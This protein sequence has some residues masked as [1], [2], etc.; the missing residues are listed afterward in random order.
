MRLSL[1]HKMHILKSHAFACRGL[2][3]VY[4]PG[5]SA[6]DSQVN[7]S[8]NNISSMP[9]AGRHVLINTDNASSK[10]L[11]CESNNG[12]FPW[13]KEGSAARKTLLILLHCFAD[14]EPQ[15]VSDCINLSR[16]GGIFSSLEG[17]C[18]ASTDY[19]LCGCPVINSIKR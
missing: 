13:I 12:W 6:T 9:P 8:G 14:M 3:V 11:L 2:P 1:C 7:N 5:I 4:P 17:A 16:M 15:E 18:Y 19:L 10:D